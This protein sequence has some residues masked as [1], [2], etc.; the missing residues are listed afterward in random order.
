[1]KI[2]EYYRNAANINLNGSIA[3]LFPAIIIVSANLVLFKNQDVMLLTVPFFLYSIFG[4]QLY[5]YKIKQSL[6]ISRNI[7]KSREMSR[8]RTLLAAREL[9]VFFINTQSPQVMFYFP[10]GYLAGSLRKYKG[11]GSFF[12]KT[13]VLYS[14]HDEVLGVFRVKTKRKIIVE[15][16]D[17]EN[18]YLGCL[19]K[20]RLA[21]RKFKKEL[22]DDAGR[23]IGFVEGSTA[24]MDEKV[25]DRENQQICRLRR[26]WMPIEWSALFPEPNTPV[27][28][29]MVGLSEKDK[30]LRMSF[31][32]N[33]YFIE[34]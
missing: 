24:F 15:V 20:K 10:D 23:Y 33:E 12:R 29:Y 31:L 8:N 27:L 3:A 22:L 14:S 18:S 34:R 30:L 1:M 4:F 13:F 5:L 11:G 9:L 6:F 2:N 7:G 32:I 16:F 25:L 19:E 28:S 26:G 21:F 17:R